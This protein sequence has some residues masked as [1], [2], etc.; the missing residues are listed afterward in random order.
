MGGSIVHLTPVCQEFLD[1]VGKVCRKWRHQKS[2][3]LLWDAFAGGRGLSWE[4]GVAEASNILQTTVYEDAKEGWKGSYVI[5][6]RQNSRLTGW[7]SG[8]Q[9]AAEQ[10]LWAGNG[11]ITLDRAPAGVLNNLVIL[12]ENT[13]EHDVCAT[14]DLLLDPNGND[15]VTGGAIHLER[16]SR[17]EN[18]EV[19]KKRI[20]IT[21]GAGSL[22]FG[23]AKQFREAG[24]EVILIDKCDE[25][26][27]RDKAAELGSCGCFRL[28]MCDEGALE[29]LVMQGAFGD[30]LDVVILNHGLGSEGLTY[31]FEERIRAG[32]DV[33][34][35]SLYRGARAL[36]PLLEKADCGA[37]LFTSSHCGIRPEPK[38]GYYC[39]AKGS[40]IG[41][42]L[43]LKE[44]LLERGIGV[45]AYTPGCL[46]NDNMDS[47]WIDRGR[48]I[49][50]TPEEAKRERIGMIPAR[51]LGNPLHAAKQMLYLCSLNATAVQL[52]ASG[53]ESLAR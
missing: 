20:L 1:R 12:D 4:T 6:M 23:A 3:V 5:L 32:M 30:R 48:D 19:R 8:I 14:L 2:R 25:E 11:C 22:G 36:L 38:L 39:P 43:G 33:N 45:Y 24:H 50:R 51:K 18:K 31:P 13:T 17:K 28:D 41:L 10:A 46:D 53:G 34:G 42:M 21:G 49:G 15:F 44:E 52:N 35:T 7:Q 16:G 40:V 9:A 26:K 29:T 47:Y 37:L 27:L